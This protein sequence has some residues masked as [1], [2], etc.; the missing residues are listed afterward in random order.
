MHL[1]RLFCRINSSPINR[2]IKKHPRILCKCLL[3]V[4]IWYYLLYLKNSIWYRLRYGGNCLVQKLM[5]Q[6]LFILIPL[7]RHCCWDAVSSGEHPLFSGP[8]AAQISYQGTTQTTRRGGDTGARS[9][10]MCWYQGKDQLCCMCASHNSCIC[11]LTISLVLRII[12]LAGVGSENSWT[13]YFQWKCDAV[14]KHL[15]VVTLCLI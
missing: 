15:M 11:N 2:W 7:G 14:K 3:R 8:P 12:A 10:K 1:V 6:R 13:S 9:G 5:Y 4:F